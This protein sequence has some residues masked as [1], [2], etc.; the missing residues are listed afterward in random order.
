MT[1]RIDK[2]DAEW[3]EQLSEDE[4]EVLR[5]QGTERA[6]TG[7]YTDEKSGGMYRCKGCG[8]PVFSSDTKYDS[9]SG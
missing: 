9:G 8:E 2:T 4:Y 5:K 6:F 1:D 3:R 7:K